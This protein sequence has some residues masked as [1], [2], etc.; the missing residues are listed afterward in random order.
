VRS[1][2]LV[3]LATL[4]ALAACAEAGGGVTGGE[5]TPQGQ[6]AQELPTIPYKLVVDPPGADAGGDVHWRDLYRDYFGPTGRPGSCL[7]QSECHNSVNA[8]G[9]RGGG[10]NCENADT[11]WQ[12]FKARFLFSGSADE[13]ANPDK[14][15]FFG[16][17]RFIKPDGT[18]EST[19]FMPKAPVDAAFSELAATRLKAWIR[20]GAPND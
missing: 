8:A 14:A 7:F 2:P 3:V 6:K 1:V 19:T 17:V 16:V 9:S 12:T 11:C 13:Q 5:L 15:G 10:P 4:A 18:V 20:R